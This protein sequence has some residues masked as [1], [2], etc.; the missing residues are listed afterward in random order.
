MTLEVIRDILMWCS[1]INMGLMILMFVILCKCRSWAYTFH[2]KWFPITE[3]Q[4][5]AI[6]YSFMGVYKTLVFMF[7]IVP[8]I[9]VCIVTN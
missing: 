6:V 7:N 1:V 5:N 9:A 4:F 3:E 8:W 2:S